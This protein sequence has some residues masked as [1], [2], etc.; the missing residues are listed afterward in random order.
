[1]EYRIDPINEKG[2]FDINFFKSEEYNDH[3]LKLKEYLKLEGFNE[4][5]K[6]FV[7]SFNGHK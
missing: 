1:M 6:P 5:Q 2:V 3:V 7:I 4:Y